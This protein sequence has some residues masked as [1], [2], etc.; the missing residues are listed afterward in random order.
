[1]PKAGV[2]LE[3]SRFLVAANESIARQGEL[4]LLR[5]LQVESS[6]LCKEKQ[7]ASTL[8]FMASSSWEVNTYCDGF[9]DTLQ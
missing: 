6:C 8:H 4:W 9:T 7:L 5:E 2:V 1:M 3:V